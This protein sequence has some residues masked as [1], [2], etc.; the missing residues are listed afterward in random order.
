[1]C[2]KLAENVV[3]TITGGISGI[4]K[5]APIYSVAC[6]SPSDFT[7]QTDWTYIASEHDFDLVPNMGGQI[8]RKQKAAEALIV[9][10]RAVRYSQRSLRAERT[11]RAGLTRG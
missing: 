7:K 1:M 2:D 9:C 3:E 5:G 8:S 4:G 11:K 10:A 6:G